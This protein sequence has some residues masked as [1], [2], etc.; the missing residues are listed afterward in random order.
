MKPEGRK[1]LQMAK[2]IHRS[3]CDEHSKQTDLYHP[4]FNQWTDCGSTE[5]D[6]CIAA[7][8]AVFAKYFTNPKR[9]KSSNANRNKILD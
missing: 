1:V 5:R 6:L 7:A 9:S 2:L 8:R 3:M 4:R